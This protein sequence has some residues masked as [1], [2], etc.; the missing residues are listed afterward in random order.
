MS[1]R[2]RE[3]GEILKWQGGHAGPG[4]CGWNP[5]Q[6]GHEAIASRTTCINHRA[7]PELGIAPDPAG[8]GTEFMRRELSEGL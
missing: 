1:A 4:G 3:R 5:D 7:S 2:A 8:W 6:S